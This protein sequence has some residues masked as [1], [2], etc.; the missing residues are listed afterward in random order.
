MFS[1]FKKLILLFT[2]LIRKFWEWTINIFSDVK[3][4]L[5]GITM[6]ILY[7]GTIEGSEITNIQILN[8]LI[9]MGMFIIIWYGVMKIIINTLWIFLFGKRFDWKIG[10]LELLLAKLRPVHAQKIIETTE[11]EVEEKSSRYAKSLKRIRHKLTKDNTRRCCK[12]SFIKNK[13]GKLKTNLRT[14]TAISTLGALVVTAG[15]YVAEINGVQVSSFIGIPIEALLVG[16]VFAAGALIAPG[17]MGA[18]YQTKEQFETMLREKKE[19]KLAK[20][21]AKAKGVTVAPE[22]EAAK[23]SK[24]LGISQEKAMEIVRERNLVKA[25]KAEE[26]QKAK[27]AKQAIKLAKKLNITTAKAQEIIKSQE[28]NKKAREQEKEEMKKKKEVTKM[29]SKLGL[30][31]A[32]AKEIIAE[33]GKA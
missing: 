13:V 32:K 11:E 6:A 22:V 5:A 14:N 31:E 17:I 29:A 28:A 3:E 30:S 20:K 4:G 9:S 24:K 16:E 18:G 19:K 2:S 33:Q 26:L 12:L 23:L 27:D 8:G 25:K 15:G 7:R 21:E 1:F 10:V